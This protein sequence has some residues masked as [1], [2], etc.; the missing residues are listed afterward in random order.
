MA[1]YNKVILMGN[2]TRDPQLSYTPTNTPVCE[3]GLAL[4]HKWRDQQ[5]NQREETCF[6]DVSAF[7][8]RGETINQYMSKGQAILIEGRLQFRQWQ[9]PEG[10]KRS[11]HSIVVD[12]F[13]F[14]GGRGGD[15]GGGGGGGGGGY[16]DTRAAS[17]S[18]G[19]PPAQQGPPPPPPQQAPAQE[20]PS[21]PP[22]QEYP[23]APSGEPPPPGDGQDQGPQ[24]GN[25][26]F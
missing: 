4:N 6:V 24:G 11:K 19:P 7:G 8:R 20:H 18:H 22:A 9:T 25:I 2:L 17:D 10:Q 12:N 1:S 14:V 23:S 5:G 13:Q 15:G 16:Q 3:F 26:P 21:A